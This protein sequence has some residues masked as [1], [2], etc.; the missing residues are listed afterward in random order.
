MRTSNRILIAA[1]VIFMVSLMTYDLG[2]RAEYLKG[3]YTKP[4][5]DYVPLNYTGFNEID[6]NASTAVNIMLVQGPFKV[7]ANPVATNFLKISRKENRLIIDAAF[8]EQYNSVNTDYILYISCP[9]LTAFNADARYTKQNI[10]VT[11]T[12]A[13]DFNWRPTLIRGFVADSLMITEN[14]AANIILQGN[15]INKLNA[16][17]GIDEKSRSNL[18]IGEK[19]QFIK[20]DLNILNKSHL[21]IKSEN[22]NNLNYHL[23]DSATLVVKGAAAKQLLK[24]N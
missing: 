5:N 12:S 6:L 15:K 23:A 10:T 18:T 24:L 8:S 17:V 14:H 9:D 13:N 11:D 3:E 22:T 2:L 21:W 20:T 7:L 1:F 4:F 16:K 19:N